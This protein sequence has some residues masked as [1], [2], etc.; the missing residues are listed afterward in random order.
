MI[1]PCGL[2]TRNSIWCDRYRRI[3]SVSHRILVFRSISGIIPG[4]S[5]P[6]GILGRILR[7][8]SGMGRRSSIMSVSG[9]T[10]VEIS[11]GTI[12]TGYRPRLVCGIHRRVS[13]C[14]SDRSRGMGRRSIHPSGVIIR[15]HLRDGHPWGSVRYMAVG[16]EVDITAELGRV[17]AGA[18]R[19]IT[20]SS[21]IGSLSICVR[22]FVSAYAKVSLSPMTAGDQRRYLDDRTAVLAPIWSRPCGD[23]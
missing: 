15:R 19:T 12:S 10:I 18:I 1:R 2:W 8:A 9:M 3:V 7:W 22:L 17:C 16:R 6:C 4:V 23:R 21:R 20:V 11:G 14:S 5:M 13:I